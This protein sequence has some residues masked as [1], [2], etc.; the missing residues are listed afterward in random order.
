M[1][2][3]GRSIIERFRGYVRPYSWTVVLTLVLTILVVPLEAS[4]PILLGLVFDTLLETEEAVVTVP[5]MNLDLSGVAEFGLWLLA[6]LVLVTILK[7][8][9]NFATVA[10]IAYLGHSVVQDVRTD[11]YASIVAQPLGFFAGN[12]TG[13]LISR[14]SS[15]VEK[16]Q[17]AMSETLVDLMKQSAIL[18]AMMGVILVIDWKLTLYSLILVPLVFLPSRWFGRRLRR[19]SGKLQSEMARH[20]Q[21]S[22]SR[23]F[24][25]TASSRSL[26]WSPPSRTSFDRLCNA[27]S[28][29]VSD[30]G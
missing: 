5:F 21:T 18:L 30:R 22:C 29:W 17:I 8:I 3:D 4:Y 13:E 16:V 10:A 11:L 28:G 14:V 15:D 23:R 27:Y 12:P 6:A 9:A 7:A 26:R 2:P 20:G 1:K 25:E 24:L 19:L